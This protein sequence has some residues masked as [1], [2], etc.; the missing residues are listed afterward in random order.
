MELAARRPNS[1]PIGERRPV[2][3]GGP[4]LAGAAVLGVKPGGLFLPG[5]LVLA[6]TRVGRSGQLTVASGADGGMNELGNA[7]KTETSAPMRVS[8]LPHFQTR[9]MP[10]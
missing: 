4:V 6:G 2:L 1:R 8:N 9:W 10:T 5:A 7:N 3:A